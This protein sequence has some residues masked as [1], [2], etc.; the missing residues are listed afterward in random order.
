MLTRPAVRTEPSAAV[1]PPVAPGDEIA[2]PPATTSSG[3]DWAP[4]SQPMTPRTQAAGTPAPTRAPVNNPPA[5]ALVL[6]AISEQDG[7]PI[8]VINERVVREGQSFDGVRILR[9]GPA[10]VE[11]E[12]AGARRI[13]RF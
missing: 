4:P 8:A 7:V 1:P 5:P 10:E 11:V 2:V 9:I 13:L 3:R 12:I 6:H